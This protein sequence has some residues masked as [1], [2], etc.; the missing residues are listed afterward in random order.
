M[1]I[2]ETLPSIAKKGLPSGCVLPRLKS[3]LMKQA[4][5]GAGRRLYEVLGMAELMR[6]AY[7]K[8]EL[9]SLQQ[10]L[11][12]LLSNAA[13]L[14][15]ELSN[16][17]E[18]SRLQ[19]QNGEAGVRDF[20]IVSL[21]QEVSRIARDAVG[22]KP[23]TVMDVASPSPVVIRSDPDRVSRIMAELMNNAV[24]FTDRGRI[25]LILNKDKDSVTLMVTDTGKGMSA[26]AIKAFLDSDDY[27]FDGE[28][29]PET[30]GLGLRIVKH[31][32]TILESKISIS[33]KIGEGT[34][35]EVILPM[36]DRPRSGTGLIP[37][38]HLVEA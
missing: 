30:G 24:K 7:E 20:N 37:S 22:E 4:T 15:A 31:L 28:I 10:R 21:L 2:T 27:A 3:L 32:V 18:L 29:R 6:V 1:K 34:I 25:A 33:S 36:S 23:V 12:A 11:I 13:D 8:G 35:V 26:E 19:M 14:S 9:E 17:L 5:K 38:R 16:I